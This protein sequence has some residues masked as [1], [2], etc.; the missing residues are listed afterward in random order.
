MTRRSNRRQ[1]QKKDDPLEADDDTNV[2][3]MVTEDVKEEEK[4]VI[5][6]D[7]IETMDQ[8]EELESVTSELDSIA[9]GSTLTTRSRRRGGPGPNTTAT[10]GKKGGVRV[11][12]TN[13]ATTNPVNSSS[14]GG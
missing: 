6:Q 5:N 10:K 1:L 13:A 7:I 9:S 12:K 11:S 14:K 4:E 3:E 2:A 8:D